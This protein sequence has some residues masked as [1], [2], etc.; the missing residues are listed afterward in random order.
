[1]FI[2]AG[3]HPKTN[4]I[5]TMPR[6]C[7]SCGRMTAYQKRIDHYFSLFFIPILR[8]KKG[9]PFMACDACQSPVA[10][11]GETR[12]CKQCGK[13]VDND[14]KFCPFCGNSIPK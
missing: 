4:T 7:P 8:V 1:M 2:V 9:I 5:D 13:P 14:F 3:V 10:V 6:H 11:P 12:R